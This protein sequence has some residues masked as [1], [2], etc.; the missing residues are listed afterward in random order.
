MG[1]VYVLYL[2]GGNYYVGYS[3]NLEQRIKNHF[4]GSGS[5]WT[6]LYK[7]KKIICFEE[8]NL[9]DEDML[10]IA[11]MIITNIKRV[12]GGSIC[13]EK[14]DSR[15]IKSIKDVEFNNFRRL[16][17]KDQSKYFN[18]ILKNNNRAMGIIKSVYGCSRCLRDS[19]EKDDCYAKRYEDGKYI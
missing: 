13:Y 17:K 18:M 8:G 19:H 7:P 11:L 12:R 3:E 5:D 15:D 4:D 16:T 1:H 6:R 2:D 14:L 10:T 9:F